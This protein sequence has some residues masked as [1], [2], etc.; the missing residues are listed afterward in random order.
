MNEK[1]HV[2]SWSGIPPKSTFQQRDKNFHRTQCARLAFAQWQAILEQFVPEKPFDGPL[3]FR[4]ILTWPFT[5]TEKKRDYVAVP[6]TTRPDG[7]NILNGVEDIMT[8]LGYWHDDNQLSVETVERYY[9]EY[10]GVVVE[11]M[12]IAA[13]FESL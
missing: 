9:G 7:V 4:L 3:S 8:E 6:K 2:F 10:P 11:I 13:G 5:K 1:K 12:E